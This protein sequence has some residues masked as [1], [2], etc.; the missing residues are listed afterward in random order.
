MKTVQFDLNIQVSILIMF[1][2][3]I[4][5]NSERSIIANI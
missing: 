4:F 3:S 1:V 2:L 5:Y